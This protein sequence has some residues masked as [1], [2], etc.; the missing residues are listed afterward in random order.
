VILVTGASGTVGSQVVR[1]LSNRNAEFRAG[2]HSRSFGIDGVET[3]HV[4]FDRPETL[5][6]ALEGVSDVFLLSSEVLHER[7]MVEAARDAGV[8]RIVKLSAF[9]AADEAFIVGRWHREVEREIERSGLTWT[10]LRPNYF[11]QNVVTVMGEDIREEDAFYD[12]VGDARISHIDARDLGRVAAHVLTEPGHEE[13]AYELS[14]PEAIT[15]DEIAETL[16][17]ALGRTIRY[18]RL[19]DEEYRKRL[20]AMGLPEEEAEAWV[21]V[22]R[23][24]RTTDADSTVTTSVRDITGR[25]PTSFEE[26]CHD[27]APDL[28]AT[29]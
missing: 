20:L 8:E 24:A 26:F 3:R 6:P 9:G 14:G 16:T 15:H 12:S 13:E 28:G 22:N 1:E 17:E 4:D 2:V 27:Y 11:M 29:P 18:V 25:E 7:A 19:S 5:G 23:V 21:D 10:F